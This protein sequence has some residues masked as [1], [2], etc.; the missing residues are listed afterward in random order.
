MRVRAAGLRGPAREWLP[1]LTSP[2]PGNARGGAHTLVTHVTVTAN[3]RDDVAYYTL[4]QRHRNSIQTLF[5]YA[6]NGHSGIIQFTHDYVYTLQAALITNI[7]H[8]STI[9]N[10]EF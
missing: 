2:T 6:K 4:R 7:A 10:D 3:A 8:S 9:I 1:S 5:L